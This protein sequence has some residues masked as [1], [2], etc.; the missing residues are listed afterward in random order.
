LTLGA[1]PDVKLSTARAKAQAAVDDMD[2]G[3]DPAAVKA[4]EESQKPNSV[5]AVADEWIIRHL[6]VNVEWPDAKRILKNNIVKPWKH[7][8]IT[9]LTR[10]DVLRVLDAVV[11]RGAAVQ[12]NRTLGVL[13]AWLNWCVERGILPVSPANGVKPPTV[14]KSRDRV[15]SPDELFEVWSVTESIEYPAGPFVRILA[16][17]AQRRG[18]VAAMR[19]QD[20]DLDKAVWTLPAESTKAGRAHDVPLSDAALKILKGVTRYSYIGDDGKKK[21]GEYVWTTTNG[22]KCINGF[23]KL[24]SHIDAETLKRRKESGVHK[25][26]ADWTMHDLRRTAATQMA[27]GGVPPHILSAILNH[28]PGSTQGVT[29]IYNRFRY[30][31]ERREALQAWAEFVVGLEKKEQKATA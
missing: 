16:L 13:R 11:D 26:I 2:G 1:Y 22:R 18:E 6:D 21:Q 3:I 27:K 14:E 19:W 20:V 12:A 4:E 25:N 28:T 29:S 15:L 5:E 7:K 23:S 10:A 9:E 24:K 31:E 17:T 8:L 30:T